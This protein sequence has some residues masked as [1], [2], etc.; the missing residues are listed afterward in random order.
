MFYNIIWSLKICIILEICLYGQARN[1]QTIYK[2]MLRTQIIKSALNY[3]YCVI[4]LTKFSHNSLA[5]IYT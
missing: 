1:A 2:K 4:N 3:E 5:R